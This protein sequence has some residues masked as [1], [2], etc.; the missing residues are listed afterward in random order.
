MLITID[1][2]TVLRR[3]AAQAL[4]INLNYIRDADANRP[5]GSR[6]LLTA[7]ND[8]GVR[9]LSYPG[10]EKSDYHRF[11]PPPYT[12]P[13]PSA[14]GWYTTPEGE[15][16]D[17]DAYIAICRA[18]GAEPFVVVPCESPANSGAT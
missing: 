16:M 8:L 1:P 2:N 17:F 11:A 14:L 9:W 10:G 18:Q 6:P 15:R 7:L 13:A 5:P 12:Q 3:D 4:G